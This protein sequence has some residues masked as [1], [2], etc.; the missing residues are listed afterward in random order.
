MAGSTRINISVVD[1]TT[2][3]QYRFNMPGAPMT[4]AEWQACVHELVDRPTPSYLVL[5][6][7]LPPGVPAEFYSYVIK[8]FE[9]TSCRILLDTSGKA[10]QMAIRRHVFLLKPNLRELG[11]LAGQPITHEEDVVIQSRRLVENGVADAIVVSLGVAGAMLITKDFVEH[12]YAP[13]VPTRS[14]IGAGDSMVAGLTW[15]L[16]QGRP[17]SQAV[18]FGVAAGTAAVMRPGTELSRRDDTERLYESMMRSQ[19]NTTTCIQ[20]SP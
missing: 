6:G 7:S 5:S 1:D 10:L 15:S 14:R 16:A 9:G 20:Y 13:L 11:E 12:V 2:G 4:T 18:Q 17:L 19:S 8:A 3:K